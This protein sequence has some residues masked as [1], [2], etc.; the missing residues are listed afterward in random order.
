MIVSIIG[1]GQVGQCYARALA[2]AGHTLH[3]LC[4]IT[5]TPAIRAFATEVGAQVTTTPGP[6][7]SEADLVISAVFGHA[8]LD[9]AAQALAYLK[10]GAQFADF[11]TASPDDMLRAAA[12]AHT[13]DIPFT[14]VAIMGAIFIA[15]DKTPLLCSGSG[16]AHV[17]AFMAA[18]GAPARAIEGQAGDAMTLKLLRSIITKGLE[19]LAVEC[20]VAADQKNLRPALYEVLAD[21]DSM[22]LTRFLESMVRSHVVHAER[23]LV[24]VQEARQQLVDDNLEPLVLDGVE[25]LFART[26]AALAQRREALATS[27]Q[28]VAPIEDTLDASLRWLTP[29]AQ[30]PSIK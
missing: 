12:V 9:V 3:T 11:T 14:D 19:S 24:E 16:A 21:V 30:H 4:D 25:R 17:A 26:A 5:P 27:P 13:H 29:L 2:A 10:P 7:L 8:A 20:L 28:S 23:R 15:R 1:V 22:P 6:W 18:C